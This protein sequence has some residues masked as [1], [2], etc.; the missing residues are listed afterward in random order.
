MLIGFTFSNS[1]AQKWREMM[2]DPNVNFYDVQEE[3]YKYHKKNQRRAKLLSLL[4]KENEKENEEQQEEFVQFKRWEWHTEQRVYPSGNRMA[5]INAFNNWMTEQQNA[6]FNTTMQL[7]NWSLMGPT[8]TIPTS[9]GG[10]GRMNCVRIH[11]TNS[12]IIYGGAAAGGFWISTNGGNSWATTTDNIPSLGVTAIAIDPVNTNIIYIGTGDGDGGDCN[13]VGVLKSTDG[14]LTWNSTGLNWLV[15]NGIQVSKLIIDPTNTNI[16]FAATSSGVF[17]SLDAAVT[18]ARVLNNGGIKDIEFKPN[19][20]NTIYACNANSFM[21]STNGGNTF[22][23]VTS[24]LPGTGSTSRLAIAVTEDDPTYVYVLASNTNGNG[25]K[26]L[27]KSTNSGSSFSQVSNS[28]NVL[29]W[30][31]QGNDTGVQGWFDLAIDASPTNKNE[32]IVGGVNIWMS[33]DGGQTWALNA[34]WYGNGAPYVH[35]DVHDL[36]YTSG[37]EFYV[38]CDGGIFHTTNSGNTYSDLSNGLQIAQMYRLGCSF[39]DANLVIQGWQDNGTA[40]YNSGSWDRVYGG[41]GMECLIDYSNAN[42]MYC[43]LY[44]GDILRSTNG[45]N[46]W[47]GITGSNLPETGDWVTPYVQDPVNPNTIYVGMNN[48]FKSTNQGNTWSQISTWG[49]S[50]L[51]CLAVAASNPNYIY[52]SNGGT[53]YRTSNGG[54][55]WT[56]LSNTL[57]GNTSITYLAISNTDPNKIWITLS[58]YQATSKVYTSDDGG[59]TWTNLTLNGGLPNLPANTIVNQTGTPNGVYV[60]TDVGVYYTDDSLGT[61][62]SFNNGLPNV[63][64]NELEIHYPSGKLRAATY[65]RGLWETNLYNPASTAPITNFK[66]HKTLACPGDSIQ[67]TDLTQNNPT[68]WSW[69]FPGGTPATSSIQNPVVYYNTPANFYNVEL[70]TTNGNGAD[71]MIKYGYMTVS[72]NPVPTIQLSINDTICSNDYLLMYASQGVAY[73]WLPS[74]PQL[75]TYHPSTA[76]Q[77]AVIVTDVFGCKDTSAYVTVVI[78][79]APAAPVI[80][81]NDDTLCS[82]YT[83]GNQWYLNGVAINGATSQC[84]TV[85][86][87]GNYY[88]VYTDTNGCDVQSN[89][90]I[91]M[92]DV[93]NWYSSFNVSPNPTTDLINIELTASLVADYIIELFDVAGKKVFTV[94]QKNTTVL[95]KKIDLSFLDKGSY[96]L[97]ITT[98]NGKVVKPII[99]I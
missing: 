98:A 37:T 16:I 84:Y 31:S 50:T 9:G 49:T 82:N 5:P 89:T 21:R 20:Y 92:N 23:I 52:A 43:E 27:Y 28:P 63:D 3:F 96:N 54:T 69:I 8:T 34:H 36:Y 45:G 25:F 99:K 71:A 48:V 83:T 67:F 87:P 39:T 12:N 86:A 85:L 40:L 51:K 33:D 2:N 77:Y 4:N 13:S 47:V 41:D 42:V 38:A 88:C 81:Q 97:V 32:V 19:S 75:S 91:G 58:G 7:G 22:S 60:G 17:R 11:P 72:A 56:N 74:G 14:G 55:S 79:Q 65:G 35:A 30:D 26:G 10:A 95:S 78:N 24:G 53:L 59:Q 70:H 80:T 29:G 6:K 61:W 1:F 44:Y 76:G 57:P 64:V 68:S 18:W 46:S 93:N 15:Q 66:A 62:I 94:N 73:S 90:L